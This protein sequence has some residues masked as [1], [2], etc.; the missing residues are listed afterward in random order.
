MPEGRLARTRAAYQPSPASSV[1]WQHGPAS[2]G[3]CPNQCG[4]LV[5]EHRRHL[6]CS[7]CQK[8]AADRQRA[9]QGKGLDTVK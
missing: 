1:D 6:P 7:R 2:Y 5:A 8:I 4:R 3:P 9:W